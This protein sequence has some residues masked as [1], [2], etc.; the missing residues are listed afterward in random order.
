[1]QFLS[2]NLYIL[3]ATMD[4]KF[5][6]TILTDLR[7]YIKIKTNKKIRDLLWATPNKYSELLAKG[8]CV[9]TVTVTKVKR[10][11]L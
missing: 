11:L 5:T 2:I 4:V 6:R 7:Q 8:Y 10:Y 3:L 1:M 9:D